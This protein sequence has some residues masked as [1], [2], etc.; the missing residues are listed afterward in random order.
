MSV[1]GC[2]DQL[3]RIARKEMDRRDR[4]IMAGEEFC[5][6]GTIVG[7]ALFRLGQFVRDF[8][9]RRWLPF[10]NVVLV[11]GVAISFILGPCSGFSFNDH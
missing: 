5:Q 4:R 2:P 3:L 8:A 1:L 11:S 9:G 10:G 7:V 6:G